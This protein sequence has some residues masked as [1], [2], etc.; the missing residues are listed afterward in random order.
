MPIIYVPTTDENDWKKRLKKP[1]HWKKEYSSWETAQSWLGA[2]GFPRSFA[3]L[4]SFAEPFAS[5][6][7][8]ITIPEHT[9]ALPGGVNSPT[10]ADVWVLASHTSGLASIAVEAKCEEGFG[11]SVAEWLVGA[12]QGRMERIAYVTKLLGVTQSGAGHVA[13]QLLHRAAGAVIEAKRF[14]ANVA[15]IAV[16][17][18]D[19][20]LTGSKNPTGFDD[21]AAFVR[22]FGAQAIVAPDVPVL[23]TW[24]NGIALYAVWVSDAIQVAQPTI[25]GGVQP[26]PTGTGET[27]AGNQP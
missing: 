18:F 20:G 25:A 17:W 8:L 13:Y 5:L 26:T 7:P 24:L 23:L 12:S 16:Q 19:K 9:V 15:V 14:K 1:E 27:I 2:A 6:T 3:F 4:A 22:L 10:Q 11:E 21:F